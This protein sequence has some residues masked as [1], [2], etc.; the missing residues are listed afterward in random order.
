M[1]KIMSIITG[2]GGLS[3]TLLWMNIYDSASSIITSPHSLALRL[4][5]FGWAWQI[6]GIE[7]GSRECVWLAVIL[8]LCTAFIFLR[9][10][11]GLHTRKWQ[12]AAS[13]AAGLT[14]IDLGVLFSGAVIQ[15]LL[16][17][18]VWAMPNI[19]KLFI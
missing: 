8:S 16:K 2:I 4:S 9:L 6:S 1:T 15:C 14:V 12:I 17:I 5:R 11:K 18:L 7:I 19:T 3:L 13:L 10:K